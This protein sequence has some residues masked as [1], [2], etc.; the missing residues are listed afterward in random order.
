M[1]KF[2]TIVFIYIVSTAYGQTNTDKQK[3]ADFKNDFLDEVRMYK[4][5]T[6]RIDTLTFVREKFPD[7]RLIITISKN[8]NVVFYDYYY[9]GTTQLE[10]TFTYD[11]LGNPIGIAKKYTEKGI[12]E[13]IMD[14]DK[15]EWIVYKKEEY[16]FYDLQSKMKLKADSL[17]SKMYG[18]DF[19]KNHVV[20]SITGSYLS[21]ENESGYWTDKLKEKPTEF[22]FRYNVKLDKDNRYEE[23]IEFELDSNGNF[24]PTS[25]ESIYGFENVPDDS[26][27][28]FKL[29]FENAMKQAKQLGLIENDTTKAVGFLHWESFEK[30]ELRNGQF[31]FYVTIKT[32]IIEN[33]VPNGRSSRI[34]KYDV[35]SFNPWTGEFAEKKKMKS[36]N[37]WGMFSGYSTGL[38]PDNE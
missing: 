9:N 23:L 31:R 12:L 18:Y 2:L 25:Y 14:Y 26:K 8:R 28:C 34:T 37:S 10:S 19:F 13:C 1:N 16:T 24:I 6:L 20:W 21:N 38:M 35:Y 3:I 36:I 5:D 30:S 27:G 4:A 29:T 33:I 17:I 7:N 15:G 32:E 22:L 11:T